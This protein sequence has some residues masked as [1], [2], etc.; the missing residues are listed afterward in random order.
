MTR[1]DR[2]RP[3]GSS[4][5]AIAVFLAGLSV[6]C[7]YVVI[8]GHIYRATSGSDIGF[9]VTVGTMA[10]SFASC[11]AAGAFAVAGLRTRR[12]AIEPIS[13]DA[14]RAAR[15]AKRIKGRKAA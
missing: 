15:D 3:D 10:L 9:I 14:H 12:P 6:V 4:K 1:N 7:G 8:A 13:I 2:H 5:L 11:L